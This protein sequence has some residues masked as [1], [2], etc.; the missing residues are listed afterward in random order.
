MT[1]FGDRSTGGRVARPD[2]RSVN[3]TESLVRECSALPEPKAQRTRS[4]FTGSPAVPLS[5]ILGLA[6]RDRLNLRNR[7]EGFGEPS[8]TRTRDSLLKRQVLYRLS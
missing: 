5:G 7:A 8:G 1:S 2:G 3:T 4:T 6:Q